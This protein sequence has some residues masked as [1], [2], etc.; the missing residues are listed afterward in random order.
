M[1]Q[2]VSGW[3]LL[4]HQLNSPQI[5]LPEQ[6]RTLETILPLLCPW[7]RR[8]LAVFS[9]PLTTL[10]LPPELASRPLSYLKPH[11]GSRQPKPMLAFVQTIPRSNPVVQAPPQDFIV[12]T[13]I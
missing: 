11:Q 5:P 3:W 13:T 7:C 6:W 2:L 9:I 10:P 1:A 4:S 8:H 12:I